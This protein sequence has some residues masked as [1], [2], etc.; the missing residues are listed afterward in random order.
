MHDIE[1][2]RC[3]QRELIGAI[4]DDGSVQNIETRTDG[5]NET[6]ESCYR[7]RYCQ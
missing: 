5:E 7:D 6:I 3:E 2:L 1:H 4:S